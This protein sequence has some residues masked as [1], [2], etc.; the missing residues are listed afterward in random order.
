MRRATMKTACGAACQTKNLT[1]LADRRPLAIAARECQMDSVSN[2]SKKS[3]PV[4]W[5]VAIASVVVYWFAFYG[6]ELIQ[7]QYSL[8]IGGDAK[9]GNDLRWL[10]LPVGSVIGGV[11][12]CMAGYMSVFQRSRLAFG[13][14]CALTILPLLVILSWLA[15]KGQQGAA[16]W[17]SAIHVVGFLIGVFFGWKRIRES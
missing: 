7:S 10:K 16:F 4:I 15:T 14:V 8:V 12:V 17:P 1:F 13:V 9:T 11:V 5:L 6:A 3:T 2:T